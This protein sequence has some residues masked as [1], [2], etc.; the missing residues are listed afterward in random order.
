M[1]LTFRFPTSPTL[2]DLRPAPAGQAGQVVPREVHVGLEEVA[3]LAGVAHVRVE[4][5]DGGVAEDVVAGVRVD[6]HR[7]DVGHQR[8]G[9][10]IGAGDP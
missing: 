3:L 10:R 1:Q 2:P 6:A 4:V 5:H 8:R 7:A 9:G